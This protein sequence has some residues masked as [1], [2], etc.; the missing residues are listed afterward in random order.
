M[1][2][3]VLITFLALAGCAAT[4]ASLDSVARTESARLVRP[5]KPFSSYA[6]YELKAMV[7]SAAVTSEPKKVQEA[8]TLEK[9]LQDKIQPLLAQ[10]RSAPAGNRSG[11]LVLEPQLAALKIVSGGARFWAGGM[12]GDSLIDLDLAITDLTSGQQVAKPRLAREAN[13]LTGAWSVGK[14]DQNLHDYIVTIA[15]QYLSDNY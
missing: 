1:K 11:T 13:G 3:L 9:K 14:S 8:M 12:A 15:Y 7:L 4:P 10:W 5:A 6:S 2:G